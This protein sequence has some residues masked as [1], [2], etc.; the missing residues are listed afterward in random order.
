MVINITP[1]PL[2]DI[3]TRRVVR[4]TAWWPKI[5]TPENSKKKYFIWLSSYF[6]VEVFKKYGRNPDKGYKWWNDG[7]YLTKNDA[8]DDDYTKY[9]DFT[10]AKMPYNKPAYVDYTNID[11][12][13]KALLFGFLIAIMSITAAELSIIYEK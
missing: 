12:L 7:E 13:I 4:K 11:W 2:P 9:Y 1:K 10:T 6:K 5:F 3:G 8:F